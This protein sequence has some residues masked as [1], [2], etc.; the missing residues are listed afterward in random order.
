MEREYI[1]ISVGGGRERTRMFVRVRDDFTCQTCKQVLL[2]SEA[3]NQGRKL[4]DVH[5]LGGKCGTMSRAYDSIKDLSGLITLCHK[6]HFNHPEHTLK[7]R[8]LEKIKE[9]KEGKKKKKI[10]DS[11]QMVL[12]RASGK[13]YAEIGKL[14]GISRQRVHQICRKQSQ[15]EK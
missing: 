3:R 8:E 5:H 6:C 4:F 1:L 7:R 14:Y 10:D 2:P 12:L 13:S 9:Y 11:Q 15:S